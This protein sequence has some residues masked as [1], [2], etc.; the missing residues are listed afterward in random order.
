MMSSKKSVLGIGLILVCVVF[1]V[2]W[3]NAPTTS[4]EPGVI[5]VSGEAD[6]RIVP[7]EVVLRLGVET[8]N[9]VLTTAKQQNDQIVKKVLALAKKYDIPT[10]HVQTD[11]IQIEPRYDNSYMKREFLNYVV[12]NTIVITLRDLTKFEAL[13]SES[14]EAGVNYV[15]NIE[16]RTTALREH[17]DEAR[18]LAIEAA[19]EKAEA[20]ATALGQKLG[21]P[22]T[23]QEEANY[24]GAG[25]S[26]WWGSYGGGMTQNVIQEIGG[27]AL[28]LDSSLSPGQ[29]SIKARVS[30]SFEMMP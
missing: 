7:D 21:N 30:V 23:L 27:E 6:V 4:T 29:I 19:R 17:R 9:K 16:F 1:L 26:S 18:L 13:L 22:R 28:N 2:G 20:M 12:Q 25:Y 3:M 15:H 24:W 10:E 8:S 11:Y 14:L 5:T